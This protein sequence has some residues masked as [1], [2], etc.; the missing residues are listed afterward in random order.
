VHRLTGDHRPPLDLAVAAVAVAAVAA[1]ATRP[2]S[3]TGG[4][5]GALP[6]VEALDALVVLRWLQTELTTIEPTLIRAARQ[7]G[8]SWQLIAPALGVASRQAAERR[9][10][11]LTPAAAGQ[12]DTREARVRAERDRRAGIRA[13]DQW[14]NA[15]TADLRR[16][17]GQITAL[18]DLGAD[19]AADIDRLHRALADPDATALPALLIETRRHLTAHTG[20]GDQVDAIDTHTRQIRSDSTNPRGGHGATG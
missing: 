10:L 19:A 13:V 4:G 14:A 12:P 6:T 8:A 2:T 15:N 20:L 3:D 11:R 5:D 18:T 16:L 7:A 17:A 9:Y 1:R